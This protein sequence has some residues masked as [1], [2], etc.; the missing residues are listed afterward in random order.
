MC[1]T[2]PPFSMSLNTSRRPFE[3]TENG[4]PGTIHLFCTVFPE[5][6]FH[7]FFPIRVPVVSIS[8]MSFAFNTGVGLHCFDPRD[9]TSARRG[10]LECHLPWRAY[11]TAVVRCLNVRRPGHW[12]G[13]LVLRCASS[14]MRAAQ[15]APL[16]L[17][18]LVCTHHAAQLC[19]C[20]VYT[21]CNTHTKLSIFVCSFYLLL[22]KLPDALT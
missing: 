19:L 7:C 9:V 15:R 2:R 22:L 4:V 3:W 13:Y 1:L 20:Y 17:C 21:T 12:C 16:Y 5:N 6:G 11:F 8:S 10:D 18:I 14:R